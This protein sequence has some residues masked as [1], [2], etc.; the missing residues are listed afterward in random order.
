MSSDLVGRSV[1][2]TGSSR[3]V[4][5]RLAERMIAEGCRV[6]INGRDL[7]AVEEVVSGLGGSVPVVGDVS[8]PDGARTVIDGTVAALGGLDVLVCNVGGGRSVPPGE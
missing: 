7:Q 2:V 8:T 1:L 4:G 5:R 3:G 6:A